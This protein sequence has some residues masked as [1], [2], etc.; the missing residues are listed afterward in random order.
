MKQAQEKKN[1]EEKDNSNTIS[2]HVE[3]IKNAHKGGLHN[4]AGG[5]EL[6]SDIY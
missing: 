3:I 5:Q 4:R 1:W 6:E 2:S